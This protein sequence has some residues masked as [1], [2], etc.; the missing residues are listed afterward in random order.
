MT[1]TDVHG[2]PCPVCGESGELLKHYGTYGLDGVR[3]IVHTTGDGHSVCTLPEAGGRM[4][5]S[6]NSWSYRAPDPL[7][8][9]S[10]LERQRDEVLAHLDWATEPC[11]FT[12]TGVCEHDRRVDADHIRSIYEEGGT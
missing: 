5:T 7:L 3:T 8:R 9:L 12:E 11:R 1:F 6:A 10:V 2:G 4:F